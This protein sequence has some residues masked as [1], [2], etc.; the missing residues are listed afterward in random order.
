M[1]VCTC[2][3]VHVCVRVCVRVYVCVCVRACVR[4]CICDL[5]QSDTKE[6]TQNTEALETYVV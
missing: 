5:F 4:A 3:C 6:L 1:C 2:A